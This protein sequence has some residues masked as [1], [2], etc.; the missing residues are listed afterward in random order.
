M[1]RAPA[2]DGPPACRVAEA[3]A[4]RD[5]PSLAPGSPEDA[6][7]L[8]RV[9]RAEDR[10]QAAADPLGAGGEHGAGGVEG[11]VQLHVPLDQSPVREAL[12][13]AST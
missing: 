7:H 2:G 13:I 8:V 1:Y 10:C 12:L 11:F 5:V 6:V 9:E 3:D 4:G